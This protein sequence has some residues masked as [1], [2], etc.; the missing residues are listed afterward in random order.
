MKTTMNLCGMVTLWSGNKVP[1]WKA[2]H[3]FKNTEVYEDEF[4]TIKETKVVPVIMF[5]EDAF[6]SNTRRTCYYLQTIEDGNVVD[7]FAVKT[8]WENGEQI[9][10]PDGIWNQDNKK[11]LKEVFGVEA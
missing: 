5:H 11:F 10:V 7:L 3:T 9:D 8:T 1:R 4:Y 6:D 2:G